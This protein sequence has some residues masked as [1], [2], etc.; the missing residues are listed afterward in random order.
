M[1]T[2]TRGPVLR[3]LLPPTLLLLAFH[4]FLP[5]TAH[6]VAAYAG[7]L[8]DAYAPAL[9]EKHEV[10]KAH[11]SMAWEMVRERTREGRDGLGRGVG[12]VVDRVQGATGLKIREALGVYNEKKARGGVVEE[13]K[14]RAVEAANVVEKTVQEVKEVVLEKVEE[15]REAVGEKTEEAK[16]GSGE[17]G[18]GKRLV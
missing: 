10:A 9:A 3:T 7:A 8:E 13:V 5:Q 2:R 12:G 14:E 4:H 15:V 16:E 6:N 18:E 11:S 1:L 17:K